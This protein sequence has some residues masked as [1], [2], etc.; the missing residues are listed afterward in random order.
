MLR[1]R[2]QRQRQRKRQALLRIQA[3]IR[4]LLEPCS[5]TFANIKDK[6]FSKKKGADKIYGA[7]SLIERSGS[8]INEVVDRLFACEKEREK[9]TQEALKADLST[10]CPG[11]SIARMPGGKIASK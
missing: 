1:R 9:E 4:P 5:N 8:R 6:A 7:P 10:R 3:R 2:Q 11:S